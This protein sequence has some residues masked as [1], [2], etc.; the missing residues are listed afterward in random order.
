MNFHREV[1]TTIT[2]TQHPRWKYGSLVLHNKNHEPE[3][4]LQLIDYDGATGATGVFTSEQEAMDN[5]DGFLDLA[6]RAYDA[7]YAKYPHKY[8]Y[9]TIQLKDGKLVM[10]LEKDERYDHYI[11]VGDVVTVPGYTRHWVALYVTQTMIDNEE[12]DASR[13]GLHLCG[14]MWYGNEPFSIKSYGKMI[15]APEDE[16]TMTLIGHAVGFDHETLR[17]M[18][19]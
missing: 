7:K 6:L 13:E 14:G 19:E 8:G 3:W 9:P 11:T 2:L 5:L 18:V 16:S 15:E 12:C 4:H 10:T 17:K 1:E